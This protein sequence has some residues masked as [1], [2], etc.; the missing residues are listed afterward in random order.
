MR[1]PIAVA[2]LLLLAQ[3]LRFQEKIEVRLIEVDAIVT[4]REGHRV[5]GLTADDFE[6]YEGRAKQPITN[7]SEY[8]SAPEA[9]IATT[10]AS[11][12]PAVPSHVREPHSLL[13]LLDS[14]PRKDFVRQKVFQQLEQM[15]KATVHDGDRVFVVLWNGG[16]QHLETIVDSS[17]SARVMASVRGFASHMSDNVGD[18][19]H[20]EGSLEAAAYAS[21]PE[22]AARD[23]MDGF[24]GQTTISKDLDE[25]AALM[26]FH[27]KTAGITR[28]VAAFGARPGR[29]ALIYVS[30]EFKLEGS[31]PYIEAKRYLDEIAAAANANGVVFY[32]V[33][34][35]MPDDMP[36]A[37]NSSET[38]VDAEDW[39]RIDGALQRLTDAT[40][41]LM[42][43]G[44]SSVGVVAPRIAEDLESYYS[45][46]YQAKSDG[47]DRVR[48]IT[49]KTKN[50]AYRVRTRT[51][52][53][54][55]SQ[56][57]KAKEAVVS[58][59]FVDEGAND[60]QFEVREG[61]LKRT[62][63]NRWLLPLFVKVPA[64]QLQFADERGKRTAHAGVLIA[65]S[66][67][68]AEVTP[69][70][71]SELRIIDPQDLEHGYVTYSVAIL[72]DKRGS[73]VS[74]GVVDRRTGAIGVRTIDNRNR[75]H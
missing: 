71:E 44:R 19:P 5:Y 39:M 42:E 65:S 21:H 61:E 56:A 48:N 66:N 38:F 73:K 70:T 32:A 26:V 10:T 28:L 37:S 8:R 57:T 45:I 55:K 34:P 43:F 13:V 46:A 60:I 24:G 59:L 74:I 16:Y 6:V 9:P 25:E 7:F 53:V 4:D 27:R 62:S 52:V 35:F 1:F 11:T 67:G 20:R 14:L 18:D 30:Q 51:K 17:D 72:G 75:F 69:V 22:I 33:R 64:S 12:P 58:R 50:P 49:V 68:V 47:G 23:R 63:G 31:F 2:A 40:G 41:G 3:D 54:E 15:L 36:D 29:K